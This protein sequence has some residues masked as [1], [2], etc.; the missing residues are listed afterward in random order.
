MTIAFAPL[1]GIG[2]PAAR[3][4]AARPIAPMLYLYGPSPAEVFLL[5]VLG[6]A[7]MGLV[8]LA[9]RLARFVKGAL[10]D[11][12]EIIASDPFSSLQ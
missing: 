4:A 11:W 8:I 6:F 3:I 5:L 10:S 9:S 7:L 1:Y 12:R 2:I